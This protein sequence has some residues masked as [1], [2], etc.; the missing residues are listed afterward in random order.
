MDW[1]KHIEVNPE[2]L[3]GKPV[4]KG[5]RLSV[6]FLLDLFAQG[7]SEALVLENYPQLQR[8]D[9]RAVFAFSAACLHDEQFIGQ[10]LAA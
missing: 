8:D 9:L 7:W 6:E 1:K 3:A 2:V 5:T 10:A 4:V